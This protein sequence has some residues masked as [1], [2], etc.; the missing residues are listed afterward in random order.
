[1]CFTAQHYSATVSVADH[2]TPNISCKHVHSSSIANQLLGPS[3]SNATMRHLHS[4]LLLLMLLL[5]LS[6]VNYRYAAHHTCRQLTDITHIT[7]SRCTHVACIHDASTQTSTQGVLLTRVPVS[8]C[9]VCTAHLH[10]F[11]ATARPPCSVQVLWGAPVN[12][13]DGNHVLYVK[14]KHRNPPIRSKVTCAPAADDN[15]TCAARQGVQG[16]APP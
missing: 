13:M 16:L 2:P 7:P 6:A 8:S 14:Q 11:E 10:T 15:D 12:L 4:L 5:L 1:L 9:R 3:C